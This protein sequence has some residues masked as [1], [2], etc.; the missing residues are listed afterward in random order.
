[1][2]KENIEKDWRKLQMNSLSLTAFPHLDLLV[3]NHTFK[4]WNFKQK[5]QKSHSILFFFNLC[6]KITYGKLGTGQDYELCWLRAPFVLKSRYE[7]LLWKIRGP[8]L[9][10]Q[11]RHV[12]KERKRKSLKCVSYTRELWAQRNPCSGQNTRLVSSLVPRTCFFWF[13]PSN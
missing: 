9:Q 11:R 8:A 1:M 3:M 5:F 7:Q 13:P 12:H 4:Y 2:K 6:A 10:L